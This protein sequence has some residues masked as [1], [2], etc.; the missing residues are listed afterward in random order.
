MK[1]VIIN[2]GTKHLRALQKICQRHGSVEVLGLSQ[3]A[4]LETLKKTILV[5]SGGHS[6][7]VK[8]NHKLYAK[9]M[10]LI[11][12]SN[13]PIIGIC[14][15]F[16]LIAECYG[17]KLKLRKKRLHRLVRIT[18]TQ[19]DPALEAFDTMLTYQAHRWMLDSVSPPLLELARSHSEVE[20]IKHMTK[21]IY[22]MQFHPEVSI[23]RNN[24]KK[25]LDSIIDSLK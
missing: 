8:Y 15:G 18:K 20:I 25:I 23:G 12:H 14:L 24:A 6:Y 5:L 21:P 4:E 2:N 17:G 7:A 10:E 22:G 13:L 3:L 9:E 1:I 11:R 19:Q 16:E